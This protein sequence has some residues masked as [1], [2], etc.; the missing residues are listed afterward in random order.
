M[1]DTNSAFQG[2]CEAKRTLG[3]R[4]EAW[5]E[6]VT[7]QGRVG[8]ALH[9]SRREG[10][11]KGVSE[12]GSAPELALKALSQRRGVVSHQLLPHPAPW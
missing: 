11:R 6:G 7:G 5:K 12:A 10:E 1:D 8:R 3:D 2:V 9:Q 4:G